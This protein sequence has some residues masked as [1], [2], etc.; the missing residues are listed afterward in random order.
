MDLIVL[1]RCGRSGRTVAEGDTC[2]DWE[3]RE[4][5]PA[6]RRDGWAAENTGRGMER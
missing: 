5:R 2:A 6:C 4:P 1:F 3:P